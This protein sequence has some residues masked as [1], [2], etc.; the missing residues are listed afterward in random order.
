MRRDNVASQELPSLRN[1]NIAPAALEDVVLTVAEGT[2]AR[3]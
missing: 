2:A 3:H 1:L